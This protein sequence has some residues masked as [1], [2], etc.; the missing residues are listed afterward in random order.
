M[1]FFL[2]IYKYENMNP[3]FYLDK[4]TNYT[5]TPICIE[6]YDLLYLP[7]EVDTEY[8]QPHYPFNTDIDNKHTTISVQYR[9]PHYKSHFLLHSDMHQIV[10][11]TEHIKWFTS[12][13]I[14]M[15]VLK[16]SGY[17]VVEVPVES[18]VTQKKLIIDI[19]G[20]FLI[21]DLLKLFKND[22]EDVIIGLIKN[23]CKRK[24]IKHDRRLR[25]YTNGRIRMEDPYIAINKVLCINGIY[26]N[27]YLQITDCIARQGN[28]SLNKFYKNCNISTETK[29]MITNEQKRNM[30]SVYESNP[31]VFEKYAK[32]DL[33]VNDALIE[34][35]KLFESLY[36]KLGLKG[37]YKQSKPTI[38]ASVKDIFSAALC[39]CFNIDDYHD[40]HTYLKYA[41]HENLIQNLQSTQVYLAKTNG[42]RCYNNRSLEP[43]INGV[44][45]DID[46]ASCY[47]KGLRFQE[48][49]LGRPVILEYNIDSN[50]NEYLNIKEFLQK[51]EHLLI[52][53]LW[54]CRITTSEQLSFKQD[55]F[56]SWYPPKSLAKII[57][58]ETMTL[59][60]D[61]DERTE[62]LE[63]DYT[64]I[65]SNEINLGVLQSDGLEWIKTCLNKKERE[66]FVTK[67]LIIT[68]G[69]YPSNTRCGSMNEFK[70]R[71]SK[72]DQKNESN[73]ITKYN[74]CE[75]HKH[76][77]ESHVW[78]S[79]NIGDIIIDKLL[80]IRQSYNKNKPSESSMNRFIK[81]IIN[82][83]YGDLVSPYFTIGNTIVGN[84]ITA[85]ARSM[86]WYMEKGLHGTQT[87]TDGCCFELN[88]V[89]KSR[90]ILTN[91][92][93]NNII[94]IG[95]IKDLTYGPLMKK[96]WT[97][98]EI[99]NL[100]QA[101]IALEALKHLQKTFRK[102][103]VLY[104]FEFEV[105]HIFDG[106]S[107]HGASNYQIRKNNNIIST[108]MRS[109]KDNEYK[110]VEIEK[111][112]TIKKINPSK[113]WLM[114]LYKNPTTVERI[115]PFVEEE[116]IKTKDYA[117]R[118][119]EYDKTN[120]KPG[121]LTYTVRLLNECTL[122]QFKFKNNKQYKSW[123]REYT[124][125]KRTYKQSYEYFYSS[126]NML[127]FKKMITEI[128]NKI[129]NGDLKYL[130]RKTVIQPHP[131][132]YE[133]EKIE[134]YIKEKIEQIHNM[135]LE[136][137]TK[138]R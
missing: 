90:Y 136:V 87:I 1:A 59:D 56:Q 131:Y 2:Q 8:Q 109:Y 115:K 100:N 30:I 33:M 43:S 107:T 110:Y 55:Y 69:F 38:G 99:E 134:T 63:G 77:R 75:I 14:V 51:Y 25:A 97:K 67:C 94:E 111:P 89:V 73:I 48:Y 7:I 45:I 3:I 26:F 66:E 120:Q 135:K 84:N 65:F 112:K 121:D 57:E 114:N 93:Y 16:E 116:I 105:K 85:R 125:L 108:K 34:N 137:K 123:L 64:K 74:E 44:L 40:L 122:S 52:P 130:K 12:D 9:L 82:T 91:A 138:L 13:S 88:R 50:C 54:M 129:D 101:D 31:E 76:I 61:H 18:S 113:D 62:L 78:Y 117:K 60:I 71:L 10:K 98:N 6:N 106:L 19:I 96:K 11:E 46:I 81:L 35:D 29:E 83:I 127:N 5:N 92:K 103:K 49:P 4:S 32:G 28:I 70:N 95:S 104:Q 53:G 80:E 58:T 42:G 128:Q 132:A 124:T 15:Q 37:Y 102:P 36:K 118:Y 20:Y 22:W 68:S 86:A 119:L 23:S 27:I 39:K 79:V 133:R 72:H 17:D 24:G 21:A 47:G 41:S 126:N